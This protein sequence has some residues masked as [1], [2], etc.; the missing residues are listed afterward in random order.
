MKYFFLFFSLFFL[1]QTSTFAL[2]ETRCDAGIEK[3]IIEFTEGERGWIH[4]LSDFIHTEQEKRVSFGEAVKDLRK[5]RCDF[6]SICKAVEYGYVNNSEVLADNFVSYPAKCDFLKD[7]ETSYLKKDFQ[8]ENAL[9]VFGK[10][11][12]LQSTQDVL[13]IKQ[14]CAKKT[15]IQF[16]SAQNFLLSTYQLSSKQDESNYYSAKLLSLSDRLRSLGDFLQR[17][18]VEIRRAYES[19]VCSCSKPN[20]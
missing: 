20:K 19:I 3:K 9:C 18:K 15:N 6:E 5:L 11:Q 14:A 12:T 16:Q 13:V 2:S 17:L 7:Y 10:D 8:G 1:L 4:R